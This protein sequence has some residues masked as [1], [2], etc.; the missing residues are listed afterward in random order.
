MSKG[1]YKVKDV[2]KS[3]KVVLLVNLL[4]LNFGS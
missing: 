3:S 4:S 2:S 1:I